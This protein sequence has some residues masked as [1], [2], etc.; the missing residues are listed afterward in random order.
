MISVIFIG[1]I[2]DIFGR[3]LTL[4]ISTLLS[5]IFMFLIPFAP[6]VYPWM[7]IIRMLIACTYAAP[8]AQPLVTDYVVKSS[9]GRATAFVA[10]G[11]IV[12]DLICFGVIFN[13]TA[14]LDKVL[15]FAIVSLI[16]SG[17]AM[18][19]LFMIKE[20]NMKHLHETK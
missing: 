17:F 1:Y 13:I 4:C 10:M 15:S 6:S 14:G 8:N 7:F 18:L 2:Y 12:G 3:R 5:A 16:V 11:F 20:P 19:F 9:R